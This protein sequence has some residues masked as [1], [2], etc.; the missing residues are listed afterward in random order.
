MKA[1]ITFDEEEDLRTALDGY[2]WKLVAWDLDQEMRRLL[3]Y[4][5]SLTGDQYDIVDK[6]R[7][8]LHEIKNDYGLKLD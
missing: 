1:T 3:K 8:K 2:K 4:D 5:E 6:L 7:E